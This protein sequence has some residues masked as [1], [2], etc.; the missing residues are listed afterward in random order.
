MKATKKQIEEVTAEATV[1]NCDITI[2]LSKFEYCSLSIYKSIG[3]K[4][5]VEIALESINKNKINGFV[6]FGDCT[7]IK[8]T[9][10]A[11]LLEIKRGVTFVE[12]WVAK[13]LI[14]EINGNTVFPAWVLNN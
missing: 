10:K 9:E 11:Y 1:M 13:S 7:I 14:Q 6:L 5:L 12:K 4:G 3:A 2:A 8:E